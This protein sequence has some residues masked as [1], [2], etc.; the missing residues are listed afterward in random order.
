MENKFKSAFG[1]VHAE[2]SLK[3]GTKAFIYEKT[4][5][6]SRKKK[7]NFQRAVMS[8]ACLLIAVVGIFGYFSYT[9]PV[10]AI[11]IDINPSIELEINRYDKVIDVKGYNDDGIRL[12]E[13]LDVRNMDYSAAINAIMENQTVVSCLNDDNV[14]EITISGN[15]EKNKKKIQ[16]CISDKTKV[17]SNNIHCYGNKDDIEA[18]HSSGL[19]VGKYR[20]YL[21]LKEENPDIKPEDVSRLTMREI[22]DMAKNELSDNS[23]DCSGVGQQ[24]GDGNGHGNGQGNGK[25]HGK[26]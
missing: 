25:R 9:I 18:A 20:A 14:L 12:A 21:E 13:E 26:N 7:V 10:A 24:H 6:Y 16:S 4:N 22:R 23:D 5:G 19:S 2:D 3:S 1:R 8:M 17:A 11:S 15:S